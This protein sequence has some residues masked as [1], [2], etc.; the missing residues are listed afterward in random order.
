VRLC[1]RHSDELAQ[2]VEDRGMPNP[3]VPP[4]GHEME[5]RLFVVET[6]HGGSE[7][8]CFHA[9]AYAFAAIEKRASETR[10]LRWIVAVDSRKEC[11]LCE[12]EARGGDDTEWVQ[13]AADDS[14]KRAREFRLAPWVH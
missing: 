2:A 9:Y 8:D 13:R 7:S 10:E 1:S 6:L 14:L 4:P 12:L 5:G 11:P 3:I